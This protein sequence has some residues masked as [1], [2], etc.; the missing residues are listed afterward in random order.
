[1]GV[2]RRKARVRELSDRGYWE[3]VLGPYARDEITFDPL[4]PAPVRSAF[5]SDAE[6]RKAWEQYGPTILAEWEA[7][8]GHPG[9]RPWGW[10]RYESG[11]GGRSVGESEADVLRRLGEL[12]AWEEEVLERQ[13]ARFA[14]V[15][16]DDDEGWGDEP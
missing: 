2:R 8:R 4:A 5:E 14:G 1:M 6:R 3:L 16:T 15:A 9:R 11:L 7:N 12:R 10:W 13:R